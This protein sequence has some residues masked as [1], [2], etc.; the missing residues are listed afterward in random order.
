[1]DTLNAAIL[2]VGDELLKGM[3]VNTNASSIGRMLTEMGYRVS[4]EISVGDN[5]EEISEALKLLICKANVIIVTGGLGPTPDDRTIAGT[6]KALKR[7]IVDDPGLR[8]IA[9]RRMKNKSD[10]LLSHQSQKIEGAVIIENLSGTAQCQFVKEKNTDIYLLPGVP[11]EADWIMKNRL[12]KNLRLRGKKAEYRVK[13]FDMY[14]SQI[15]LALSEKFTKTDIDKIAFLPSYGSVTLVSKEKKLIEYA[16][17]KF[18]EKNVI[19]YGCKIEEELLKL[20]LLKRLTLSLAESCTGGMIGKML[21]DIPGS[22]RVFKGGIIA[23]SNEIKEKILKIED[24]VII[25][26]GAVSREVSERMAMNV[27]RVF[28]T[29]A[30]ISVT[31]IAGPNGETK[32]KRTGLVYISTCYK[33]K[34]VTVK[35]EFSGDRNSVREKSAGIALYNLL[36]RV[37]HE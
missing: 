27:T 28:N 8:K 31:G 5:E 15:F 18:A 33:E 13:L 7:K 25:K 24:K 36:R 22:S 1:M 14:E 35:K 16:K 23:Y 19:P 2:S 11:E 30:S 26:Y 29:D 34:I 17:E 10:Y 9:E 12:S 37:Q 32:E 4:M 20:L 6:A 21:T 3:T